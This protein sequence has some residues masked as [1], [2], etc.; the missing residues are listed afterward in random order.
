MNT[1]PAP[2]SPDNRLGRYIHRLRVERGWSLRRLAT[3]AGMDATGLMR[4]EQ[5]KTVAPHPHHLAGLAEALDIDVADLYSAA[6]YTPGREL[7]AFEPYLRAKYDLP[8]E[9]VEQLRAHFELLDEKYR[10]EHEGGDQ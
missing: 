3:M 1:N 5:G 2:S 7:P 4:L 10:R 6:N 9:A 8:P